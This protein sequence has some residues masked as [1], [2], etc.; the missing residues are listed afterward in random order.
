MYKASS[1]LQFLEACPR[2]KLAIG[3]GHLLSWA[4]FRFDQIWAIN[5]TNFFKYNNNNES[6][7]CPTGIMLPSYDTMR[8]PVIT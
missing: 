6:S 2:L 3:I 1:N 4:R 8:Q 7:C 5:F